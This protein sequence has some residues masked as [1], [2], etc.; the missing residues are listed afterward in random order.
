MSELTN[1]KASIETDLAKV[2]TYSKAEV[3]KLLAEFKAG[4]VTVP[5]YILPVIAVM[6]WILI[7]VTQ[8]ILS[9]IL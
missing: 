8:K 5:Y 9:R 2:E 4:K 1:I 7:E 3:D 6:G